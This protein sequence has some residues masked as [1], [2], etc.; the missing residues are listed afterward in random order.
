MPFKAIACCFLLLILAVGDACAG[1]VNAFIYHR[2]DEDRYPSTNISAEIFRQQL[3]YLK[4]NNIEVISLGEI[5]ARLK[6]GRP[7]PAHAA[8]LCVDDAYRSFFDVAMPILREYGY[9]ITL[10]VNTD[11][12]GTPGYMSWDE[13]RVLVDEGVE[14]GNHTA[15]HAYLV[16]TRPGESPEQWEQRI[17]EDILKAQQAFVGQLGFRPTL[18]AYPYG[19]YSQDVV[20]IVRSLGF[21]AAFAQQSGV[22]H[23]DH[24]RFIL[25]RFPMGGP[26]A[27]LDGFRGKLRMHALIVREESPFDPLVS[28][29]PPVLSLNLGSDVQASRINCFV[30]GENQCRVVADNSKGEGWYRVTADKPLA[31]RRNK[32]TL[33]LQDAQGQWLWYSHP[34]IILPGK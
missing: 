3:E 21:I 20:E 29:N 9:P 11:A 10:F 18:F 33:T 14:I 7:L 24:D 12:T 23:P 13:L 25:P 6:D 2:F 17:R 15:T 28:N 27:T 34:W 1:Q 8:A 16:E 19:E 30:Q 31:G 32:Y 4:T 22:I 26:F 5:A